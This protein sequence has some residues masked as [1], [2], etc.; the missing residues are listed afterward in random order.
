ML[1]I[2]FYFVSVPDTHTVSANKP[3]VAHVTAGFYFVCTA[4]AKQQHVCPWSPLT[5]DAHGMNKWHT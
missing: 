2:M 1:Y 5:A 4:A 3:A